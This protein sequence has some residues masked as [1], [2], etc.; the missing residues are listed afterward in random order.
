MFFRKKLIV[1]IIIFAVITVICAMYGY[2][3]V[4][5]DEGY[6]FFDALYKTMQ[7]FTL[8]SSSPETCLSI[9]I[10]RFLAPIVV[11]C[12]GIQ[13]IYSLSHEGWKWLCMRFFNNHVVVCG[14][15]FT[16]KHIVKRIIA[17]KKKVIVIDPAINNPIISLNEIHIK[18]DASLLST[19]LEARIKNASEIII[20]TGSDYINILVCMQLI[21]LKLGNNI[22]KSVRIEQLDNKNIIK[23]LSNEENGFK[24]FNF[25]E[26]V[27][28]SL[29]F[30]NN[31]NIII[32]GLGSIGKRLIEKYR[33]SNRIIAIEQ[34]NITLKRIKDIYPE[35]PR[36][37]YNCS[38][39]KGLV[40]RDLTKYLS[41]C[42]FDLKT[43]FFEVFICLG[44]DWLLFST[45]CKWIDWSDINMKI[46][47]MG[48]N[49]EKELID[50]IETKKE[51]NNIVV[52]NIVDDTLK[53]Y[54]NDPS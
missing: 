1:W 50:K 45:A 6:S 41:E 23:F 44:A 35:G 30:I 8:G 3:C 47:L 33:E 17:Q 40:H 25:S 51:D 54:I 31:G 27:M 39:I 7:L 53:E 2:L 34:S 21:K 26:L 13:L 10:A 20:S 29:P 43:E 49:I 24:V 18:K 14:Y 19:L 52:Y 12:G 48:M 36:L 9:N 38:D 28:H 32:L 5:D 16:G 4:H 42:G 11:I 15:G 37:H 46:T 22:K